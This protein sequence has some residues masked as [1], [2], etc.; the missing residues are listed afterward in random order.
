MS[1]VGRKLISVTEGVNI[2]QEA[3][4]VRVSGPKGEISVFLPRGISIA[5]DQGLLKVSRQDASK[6]TKSL[7]GSLQRTLTNAIEGVLNGWV[8]KMELVG[9]GYRSRLE[10]NSLVLAIGFSHPVRF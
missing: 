2:A 4:V 3:D 10:G 9:T 5:V 6:Q 7:H 8:K 1:R